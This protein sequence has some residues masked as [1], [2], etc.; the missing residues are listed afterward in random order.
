MN[1]K[2]V[3]HANVDENDGVLNAITIADVLDEIK[4]R[5]LCEDL[6][7]QLMPA[8]IDIDFGASFDVDYGMV[9]FE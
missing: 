3:I 7:D 1:F 9:E 8:S 5:V 2:L 6:P 4:E